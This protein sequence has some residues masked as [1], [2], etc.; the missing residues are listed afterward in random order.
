[1]PEA[2]EEHQGTYRCPVC[3]HRDIAV[4]ACGD[5]RVRVVCS[6]CEMPLDVAGRGPDSVRLSA[7][8]AGLRARR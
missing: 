4:L 7:R 1:M 5:S 2:S 6:Y 3:G 8:V